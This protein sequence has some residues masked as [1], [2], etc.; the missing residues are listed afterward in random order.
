MAR[1]SNL[2]LLGPCVL[3]IFNAIGNIHVMLGDDRQ[4]IRFDHALWLV[5]GKG[6]FVAFDLEETMVIIGDILLRGFRFC[7]SPGPSKRTEAKHAQ[8]WT[9]MCC[10]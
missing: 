6:I 2:N 3:R 4:L 1:A 7:A 9:Y 8:F 5:V 10:C